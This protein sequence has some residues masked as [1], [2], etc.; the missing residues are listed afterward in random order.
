MTPR[1]PT[2]AFIVFCAAWVAVWLALWLLL[3]GA[4]P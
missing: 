3:P 2:A 4:P 1:F